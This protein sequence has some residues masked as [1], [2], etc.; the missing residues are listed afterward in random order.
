MIDL[1]RRMD[2]SVRKVTVYGS[3]LTNGGLLVIVASIITF[4]V[5][6]LRLMHAARIPNIKG[7]DQVIRLEAELEKLYE[8]N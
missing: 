3:W 2:A 7:D 5:E 4:I 8:V 1:N 6:F